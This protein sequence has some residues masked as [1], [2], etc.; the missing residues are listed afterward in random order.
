MN[1]AS[2]FAVIFLLTSHAVR[3]AFPP[4]P[5]AASAP[6][7]HPTRAYSTAAIDRYLQTE[8]RR[9]NIPGMSLA[10][11]KNGEPL[12]VKGYGLA[13]LELKVP[14]APQTV[15]QIGSIGKQF[16]AVAVMMLAGEH[17]LDLD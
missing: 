6:A 17:K 12:Y 16:T 3:A 10:V 7:R 9:Q 13:T 1:R 4:A 8:M 11:V 14:A 2:A 5:A 15:Y